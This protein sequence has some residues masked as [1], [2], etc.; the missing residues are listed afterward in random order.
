[1]K[2]K[3]MFIGDAGSIHIA[4]YVNYY[5]QRDDYDVCIATFSQTNCTDCPNAVFLS[6]HM[7]TAGGG[8]YHYLFSI[9]K[10]AKLIRKYNPDY[11]NAHFS[12]SM[13]FIALLALRLSG[14]S[15]ELSVVCHGSDVMA[16][17]HRWCYWLNKIVLHS[18]KKI[19]AVSEPMYRKILSWNIDRKKIFV[20]Q[21]GV[22]VKKQEN[23]KRDIDIISIRDASPNSRIEFMLDALSQIDKIEQKNLIFVIPNIENKRLE[24]FKEKYSHIK[25]YER[26]SH[27][28]IVNLLKRSRIYIS[29]TKSDGTSLSLLEAMAY[30]AYPV[31]SDI[32][33]NACWIKNDINGNLFKTEMEFIVYVS[34]VL[35]LPDHDYKRV[36]ESNYAIVDCKCNY[37]K[38]MKKIEQFLFG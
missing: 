13:G 30:G 17:S 34:R 10:L 31:V 37:D 18:A 21:Y 6:S 23:V 8:N 28:E 12:Y 27:D 22:V 16:Y 38:Q 36:S 26:I 20:G 5:A 7:V 3:I 9:L 19:I 29:A 2:K 32:P 1:M 35:G 33:T 4:K 15:S 24:V 14:R 11:I 25:F